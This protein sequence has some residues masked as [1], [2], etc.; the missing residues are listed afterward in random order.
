MRSIWKGSIGFGLVNIPI[1]LYPAVKERPF[2]FHFLHKKDRGRI[3]NERVCEVCGQTVDYGDLVRGYEYEKGQYVVLTDKDL[4]KVGA[5]SSRHIEIT[6]FVKQSEIDPVFFEKPYYLAPGR[7]GEKA[8]A[9]FQEVLKQ[10]QRIGIG[11][12]VLHTREQLAA[13]RATDGAL[14]L[15]ILRFSD[16]LRDVE[17]LKL[18]P[19]KGQ[20]A[21]KRELHLA[22]QLISQLST[23]FDPKKYIDTYHDA[24]LS[25]IK[26]KLSG[27]TVRAP[28]KAPRATNVVDLMSKLKAS[29]KQVK[30]R[31][32]PQRKAVA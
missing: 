26:R 10:N 1:S 2:D 19:K 30:Q 6:D 12:L 16:E 8:Y 32:S 25:L 21:T 4:E 31:E 14:M 28:I 17:A 5:Q 11:R 13:V 18:L 9:L 3:R 24:L 23:R 22:E 7:S 27:E 20:R 29:L 15:E